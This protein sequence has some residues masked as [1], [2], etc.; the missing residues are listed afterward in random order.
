MEP[1]KIEK[2][3]VDHDTLLIVTVPD[4]MPA[5]AMDAVRQQ[6]CRLA[7]DLQLRHP[8]VMKRSSISIEFVD[9]SERVKPPYSRRSLNLPKPNAEHLQKLASDH[10]KESPREQSDN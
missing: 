5:A 1:I 6:M 3:T 9:Q 8:P 7:M 2:T 4:S 10:D